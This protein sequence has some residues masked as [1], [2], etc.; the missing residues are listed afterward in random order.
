MYFFS[1]NLRN[2][3]FRPAVLNLPRLNFSSLNG[4][5]ANK[6]FKN[7]SFLHAVPPGGF[8][9]GTWNVGVRSYGMII[10]R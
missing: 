9:G 4:G 10:A 7:R 3:V 2:A 1:V 6:K 8:S 5:T